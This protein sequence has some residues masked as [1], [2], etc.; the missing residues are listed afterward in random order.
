MKGKNV[1]S[2]LRSFLAAL[3]AVVMCL[4]MSVFVF[5]AEEEELEDP[6]VEENVDAEEGTT[7][8]DSSGVYQPAETVTPEGYDNSTSVSQIGFYRSGRYVD[9]YN[10]YLEYDVALPS[11]LI[12]GNQITSATAAYKS[13]ATYEGRDS[14]LVMDKT[15]S[16]TYTV[17]VPETGLYALELVYFPLLGDG[18]GK[19][20]ELGVK[21]DGKLPHNDANRFNLKRNWAEEIP[22]SEEKRFDAIGNELIMK[23][24]ES[25]KWLTRS[26]KDPDGVFDSPVKFYLTAGTHTV[27]IDFL[28]GIL[29]LDSIRFYNDGE[30]KSYSDYL[31]END[32]M[33]AIDAT[34]SIKLEAEDYVDKSES[35]I[36]PAYDRSDPK[37]SPYSISKT[38][39]NVLG[40]EN[41]NT[42]GQIVN[43]EI[44]VPEGGAGYYEIG[45]RYRQ[46]YVEDSVSYRR[47]YIDGV[48]PFA[49]ANELA[50]PFGIGYHYKILSGKDE[51]GK[52]QNYKFYLD[53]GKHTI[54]MEAV[55]GPMAQ[56]SREAEDVV[57]Q[58][59]YIYRKIIMVT[60]TTPDTYRDYEL[61]IK[62]DGL[63]EMFESVQTQVLE[64]EKQVIE[65]NG[66]LGSASIITI[67]KKQLKDFIK[68]P[69]SIPDRLSTFKDNI[70]TFSSW[71]LDLRDQPVQFDKMIFMGENADVPRQTATF[72]E[73]LAH[74][75]RAFW[76]S[77]VDDYTSVGAA[78]ESGRSLTVWV[79][80]GRDQA[81]VLKTLCDNF[82]TDETGISV[83][84]G[85]VPLGILSK[86]IVAG[87]GPDIAL[88][89]GRSEPMNLGVRNAVYDISKFDDFDEVAKRFTKYALVPYTL[90][91]DEVDPE[92]NEKK[93]AV[94]ALPETQNFNMMFYRTDI[95]AELGISA[96]NTWDE[97]DDILPYIQAN[98]MTVGLDSHLGQTAPTTG[99]TFYSFILQQGKMPYAD[100]GL[101]TNFTE[102]FAIEAFEKWT[103]YYLQY[104]LPTD[105]DWYTRFR[106]GEM[107][108]VLQSYSSITYLQESAPELNGLWKAVPIPGTKD[109]ETGIINRSEES[110]GMSGCMIVSKTIRQAKNPEQQLEDAWTFMKWWTSDF[111]AAEY[112]NRVEMAIGSVARYTTA[113][114][115]AFDKIKWS[116][117]EA[118]AIIEQRD[119]VREIPELVGGY[120]VG[121]NLINAFRNVTNNHSNPREKLFY[122][123]EQI[124]E[125]IWRKRSEYNLSVPEEA[126]D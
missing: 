14:V 114:N 51:N 111:V 53:E 93:T 41:W 34:G 17:T 2:A 56:V 125:E 42:N 59:N 29:A 23:Q 46:S 90:T 106:N 6:S 20:Y 7:D 76:S 118:A 120:Y 44:E 126:N 94:F 19:D 12:E 88:H 39:L 116:S 57:Y 123:N 100:G 72:W 99:G 32:L 107:P 83:N 113:N 31:D 4:S 3:L 8:Q 9:Y 67:L 18:N 97:F 60:G 27:S 109:P 50:F 65:I 43:W 108:L 89:V 85:L 84:V 105:Y 22:E 104:D 25:A 119:D 68:A 87:R 112:G 55:I 16:L 82:F 35:L 40:G 62:I 24:E 70:S 21:I 124:N 101:E 30:E 74:E 13:E 75:V 102:Q 1:N 117:E 54:S 71:M 66:S 36:Q 110:T 98:N 69:Y 92:T 5:A 33:G 115:K 28:V 73:N 26:I 48:V 78:G 47:L 79:G 96:P 63:M 11:I 37:V 86:A 91:L 64:I 15:G 103:R 61:D 52:K 77:F 58:M 10:E 38:R 121:R 49:E 122:Y 81:T 80:T 95:F 45:V